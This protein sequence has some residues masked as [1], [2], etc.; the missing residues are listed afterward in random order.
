MFAPEIKVGAQGYQRF[1]KL[2]L[3]QNIA[4]CAVPA[5]TVKTSS[6]SSTYLGYFTP[7]FLVQFNL[8]LFQT[9][10]NIK[11]KMCQLSLL[12]NENVSDKLRF[13]P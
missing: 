4:L 12:V 3:G 13:L 5:V 1:L 7:A 11:S 10:P 8:I 6:S 2:G 9:S